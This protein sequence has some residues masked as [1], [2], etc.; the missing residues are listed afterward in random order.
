MGVFKGYT[1]GEA[2]HGTHDRTNTISPPVKEAPAR[3]LVILPLKERW[4]G[5]TLCFPSSREHSSEV[6]EL[7]DRMA[8][9][10]TSPIAGIYFSGRLPR[11][12]GSDLQCH[13]GLILLSI[14]IPER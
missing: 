12:I 10:I 5:S 3:C 2:H 6:F 9:Q 13:I 8:N 11:L 1:C 4:P 7:V 14:R